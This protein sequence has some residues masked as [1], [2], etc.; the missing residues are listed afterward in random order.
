MSVKINGF[1]T[2]VSSFAD[3]IGEFLRDIDRAGISCCTKCADGTTG[4]VDLQ[5]IMKTSRVPHYPIFR[6]TTFPFN[7]GESDIP[8]PHY[9]IDP[10]DAA[11]RQWESHMQ[12]FPADLDP[13]IV[14][15]EIIN[16]PSKETEHGTWIAEFLIEAATLALQSGFKFC[17]PGWA[18]GN[19]EL[20][21]WQN[22]RILDFLALC[23]D[24]RGSLG[25]S[26]HEYSLTTDD[27]MAGDGFLVGRFVHM[28]NACD[29]NGIVHP[30]IFMTEW[31][32]EERNVPNIENAMKDIE[33][34]AFLYDD[35]PA[36]KGCNIWALDRGWGT[37]HEQTHALMEPLRDYIIMIGPDDDIPPVDPPPPSFLV[38][39]NGSFE[40]TNW[41][42]LTP[43]KRQQVP[44]G[45]VMIAESSGNVRGN[46]ITT[47]SE[48]VHKNHDNL[49]EDE[50]NGAPNALVLDGEQSLKIFGKGTWRTSLKQQIGGFDVLERVVVHWPVNVHFDG[51]P[52]PYDPEDT[53]VI[54][55]INGQHTVIWM[56]KELDR[57][58]LTPAL[59]GQADLD[60]LVDV[61][62]EISVK[63][64]HDTALFTDMLDIQEETMIEPVTRVFVK[65]PQEITWDE[66]A[67][68]IKERFENKRTFGFS[69]DDALD[70]VA[71]GNERSYIEVVNPNHASQQ[72]VIR[73]ARERGLEVKVVYAV[74]PTDILNALELGYLFE[75]RYTWTSAFNDPRDYGN[76]LHEGS[77]YDVMESGPDS[78]QPVLCVYPGIVSRVETNSGSYANYVVVAHNFN[79]QL[80]YTWYAHLDRIYVAPNQRL[81]MG[82]HIGE[83]GDEGGNWGEHV[84]FNL[85]ITGR[86]NAGYIIPDVVD[87]EPYF[88]MHPHKLQSVIVPP[89]QTPV[90]DLLAYMR[91]DGR[92][93]D[94]KHLD[95]SFETFQTQIDNEYPDRFFQVKNSQWEM[96][97]S[98]YKGDTEHIWRDT[99]ISP[100]PAP[101]T[102]VSPERPGENRFYTQREPGKKAARWVKREMKVGEKFISPSIHDVAFYYKRDCFP[103]ALNSGVNTNKVTFV[104]HH[105]EITFNNFTVRDVIELFTGWE[106]MFYARGYGLVGWRNNSGQQSGIIFEHS[107]PVQLQRERGCFG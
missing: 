25:V 90:F 16:E 27:I 84:H 81:E 24:H 39:E 97:Y 66:V 78:K 64:G 67:P 21:V 46:A 88:K 50:W 79:G 82:A 58:W 99:D 73:L 37:L 40:D 62:M 20:G 36:V 11:K 107:N 60:G 91:G 56:T 18:T 22:S 4:L 65:F 3:G 47:T 95:G 44:R 35:Y 19:P 14:Y 2:S 57:Q 100:G 51:R 48:V 28:L 10:I 59:Y 98:V 45:F 104:A 55:R 72:E 15:S 105:D 69:H 42:H 8:D 86:G 87:P 9:Q 12:R 33:A 13:T 31:G 80:F 7:Q 85:Q 103:S 41:T 94:V 96:M 89:S 23:G 102:V 93:Y 63:W 30:D 68:L 49:P 54:F 92:S 26:L 76:G 1:H 70:L 106:T 75:V 5:N 32:W 77:D 17:G 38:F 53:A 71:L 61:E 101:S 74:P 52:D 34:A 83:I 43:D 6:R 29:K